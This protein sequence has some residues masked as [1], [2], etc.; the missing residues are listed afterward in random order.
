MNT[1]KKILLT[2]SRLNEELQKEDEM[3]GGVRR[4]TGGAVIGG[5]VI[6][7]RQSGVNMLLKTMKKKQIPYFD[8]Q[9]GRVTLR[10]YGVETYDEYL[11]SRNLKKN[12]FSKKE[13]EDYREEQ[14]FPIGTRLGEETIRRSK[15]ND[16]NILK[17]NLLSYYVVPVVGGNDRFLKLMTPSMMVDL[18]VDNVDPTIIAT[19]VQKRM[20][21]AG[22]QRLVSREDK[23]QAKKKT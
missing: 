20:Q 17:Q 9:G 1:K 2:L 4:K 22:I 5:A 13:Y 19:S 10:D 3:L 18:I 11:Q 8:E 21:D 7:G 23:I 15:D 6:G 14:G 12:A 16:K